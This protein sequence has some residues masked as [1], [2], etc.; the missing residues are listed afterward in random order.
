MCIRDSLDAVVM[1]CE[2]AITYA[3]RYASLAREMARKEKDAARRAELEKIASNC[4]NVPEN[5]ASGFYEACQSFWFIQMLLQTESSGHS[6]SPGRFD[7]YMYCL[8]YT[9]RCV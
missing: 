7:Q 2:A 1:S 3:K 4:D 9:S 5:G 6:I 8:L